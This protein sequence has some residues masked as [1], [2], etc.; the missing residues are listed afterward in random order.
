[1]NQFLLGGL[2]V[3]VVLLLVDLSESISMNH[4]SVESNIS[5]SGTT[6][7]NETQ[8]D[9]KPPVIV[10]KSHMETLTKDTTSQKVQTISETL[11]T[12]DYNSTVAKDPEES[13]PEFIFKKRG[14]IGYMS[15]LI[16][17]LKYTDTKSEKRKVINKIKVMAFDM[18]SYDSALRSAIDFDTIKPKIMSTDDILRGVI[19]VKSCT[20]YSFTSGELRECRVKFIKLAAEISI[21]DTKKLA[22]ER[23]PR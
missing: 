9:I 19:D 10:N 2:T 18:Y 1:M 17:E 7:N 12:T 14:T 5:I 4:S 22:I 13:A 15:A 6:T 8:P 23:E 21:E 11:A 3:M 16:R 20:N